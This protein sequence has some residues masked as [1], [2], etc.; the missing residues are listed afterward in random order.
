MLGCVL[1]TLH[2]GSGDK[3]LF[4]QALSHAIACHTHSQ[5]SD[6]RDVATYTHIPH[7][8]GKV[9]K[10]TDFP[11]QP[12]V[13]GDAPNSL[14]TQGGCCLGEHRCACAHQ[15]PLPRGDLWGQG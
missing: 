14:S 7:P 12:P 11:P 5:L 2:A 9:A 10:A 8:R 1:C 15:L 13:P 3:Q 6:I 4:L